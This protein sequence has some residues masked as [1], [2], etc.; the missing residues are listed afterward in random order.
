MKYE[1]WL[2]GIYVSIKILKYCSFVFFILIAGE[3]V[4]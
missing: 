1:E 4:D 2:N 3:F